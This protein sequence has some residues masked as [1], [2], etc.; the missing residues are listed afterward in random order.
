MLT[1]FLIATAAVLVVAGPA[2]AASPST[3]PR[4][5]VDGTP[6]ADTLVGTGRSEVLCGHK[7]DD[8]IVGGGGRDVL[9][10]GKGSDILNARDGQPGDWLIGAHGLDTCLADPG[11][12]V[13]A[14]CDR[15]FASS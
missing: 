14:S 3:P 2:G 13:D 9:R 1:R 4:C 12:R 5:T 6:A 10:G 15:V 7:G 8:L 11:D